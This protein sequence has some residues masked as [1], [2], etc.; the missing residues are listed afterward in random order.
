MSELDTRRAEGI[1]NAL[2]DKETATC[3]DCGETIDVSEAKDPMSV[4]MT[5]EKHR[6]T[7][8]DGDGDG[9]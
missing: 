5:L 9:E 8:E 6:Q 1:V 2:T 3:S 7:H 4:V